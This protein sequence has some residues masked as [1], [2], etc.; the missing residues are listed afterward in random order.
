MDWLCFLWCNHGTTKSQV[1]HCTHSID[2]IFHKSYP[3]VQS[4]CSYEDL[5]LKKIHICRLLTANMVCNSMNT[6]LRFLNFLVVSIQFYCKFSTNVIDNGLALF[7]VGVITTPLKVKWTL[8]P[9]NW[10][11]T[12]FS[13]CLDPSLQSSKCDW[14]VLPWKLKGQALLLLDT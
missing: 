1:E 9:S 11:S 8:H 12:I 6:L 10:P 5:F 13:T 7:L 14:H 2:I 3:S 4:C